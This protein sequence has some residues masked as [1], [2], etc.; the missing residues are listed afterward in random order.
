MSLIWNIDGNKIEIQWSL[1]EANQNWFEN[2]S[3]LDN[4]KVN[5]DG[6]ETWIY[7]NIS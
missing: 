3:T 1:R 4:Y 2:A 5:I 6:I 7:K